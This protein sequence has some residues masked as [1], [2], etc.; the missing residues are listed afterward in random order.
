MATHAPVLRQ[1]IFEARYEQGYR[2]LDRCGDA[3]VILEN[4]LSEQT[5]HVW[6]PHEA[7]PTSARL[8]CPDL[9]VTIVFNSYSMIVDQQI[10][11]D[12]LLDFAHLAATTL[13]TLT[14]RF[15]LRAMRRFG[16]RRVHILA[17]ASDSI[18]DAERLSLTIAPDQSWF[19]PPAPELAPRSFEQ[20][21]LY[22]QSD[23]AK[24]LRVTTKP[25]AKIGTD[26][27]VDERLNAPPHHFPKEQ[28]T[29]LIEQ[30]KR[31]KARQHDPEAGVSIDL[32]F[33]YLWPP[34]TL[35][36]PDFV[37]EATKTA[38]EALAQV[39]GRT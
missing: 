31:A 13:A 1:R 39:I 37:Q 24:G 10:V 17:A 6:L 32:D 7:N 20:A 14:G 16:Y 21:T 33:Y 5:S 36:I 11:S 19:H 35:S 29:A 8:Q 27:H 4:L 23:R 22:E 9:D 26:L 15:D 30:L 28:R 34:K 18:D 2:Y 25:Y 38:D 3:L 12:A